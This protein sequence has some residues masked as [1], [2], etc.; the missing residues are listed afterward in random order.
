MAKFIFR[1]NNNNNG[2]SNL[3][4]TLKHWENSVMYGD[5]EIN[6]ISSSNPTSLNEPTSIPSPFAR[7][8]LAKTAFSEVAE[9]GERALASYQKIVSD[10]LD[11]AEIFFTFDKWKDKIDIIKW[12][13]GRKDNSNELKDDSDLKKLEPGHRQLYKT[14][15]TFLEN[16]AVAYNFDRMKSLFILKHKT[17]GNMIGATSPCTL[18]FSSAND[19]EDIDI[20]LNNT[21]KAFNDII[22]LHMRSWDFQKYLYTWVAANNENRNINGRAA[23]SI[24]HEFAK[25]LDAQKST[26][27]RIEEID[28]LSN[29]A[30]EIL[31]KSF[32]ALRAPDVEVLGKPL[33]QSKDV[34]IVQ[35]YLTVNDLLEDTII[36]LPGKIKNTSF[37]DGN[38]DENAQYGYLLP[39]KEEFFRHFTIKC[40]RFY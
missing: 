33:Y 18:F 4:N 40:D 26:I 32:K 7:I 24:F 9:H 39:L 19:F 36:R 16:D 38:L 8:A 2:Q 23:T 34:K 20:P 22:P 15:K 1:L 21:H 3:K 28:A 10:C 31:G 35:D 25:Y 30:S 12:N 11:V 5:T 13:Y 27:D 37:F 17:T 29:N 14:L 6:D